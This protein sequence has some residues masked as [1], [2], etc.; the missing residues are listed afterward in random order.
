MKRTNPNILYSPGNRLLFTANILE[1]TPAANPSTCLEYC[2]TCLELSSV[3]NRLG[4]AGSLNSLCHSSSGRSGCFEAV[5]A[6]FSALRFC[7]H[8]V[9]LVCSRASDR[10]SRCSQG[11]GR[12]SSRGRGRWTGRAHRSWGRGAGA[13]CW[14]PAAG[15][16]GW[17]GSRAPPLVP[18]RAAGGAAM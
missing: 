10:W 11:A 9:I 6:A 17:A 16:L 18:P 13:A 14:G 1:V 15:P 8:A 2:S 7:C 5:R 12:T 4:S 3:S